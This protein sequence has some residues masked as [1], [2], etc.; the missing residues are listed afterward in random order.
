VKAVL[1]SLLV[2]EEK[3]SVCQLNFGAGL[4][5]GKW[6]RAKVSH[7]LAVEPNEDKLVKGKKQYSVKKDEAEKKKQ[8]TFYEAEFLQEEL[9]VEDLANK[10]NFFMQYQFV[11]CFEG[12]D[13]VIS[14]E[15][16]LTKLFQ[17]VSDL[18][19]IGGYFFGIIN[20]SRAI[21]TQ[22]QKS[23]IKGSKL[24]EIK[25][26]ILQIKFSSMNFEN[27][28]SEYTWEIEKKTHSY[29]LIHF[30]TFQKIA[31]RY[32]FVTLSM[33]NMKEFYEDQKGNFAELL[34]RALPRESADNDHKQAISFYS[35]FVL[36]KQME[37]KERS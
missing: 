16:E 31:Q 19:H 20:D 18:L 24:P 28:G 11:A 15:H 2:R 9:T 1:V 6:Y 7:L 27:L 22:A 33:Q 14:N 12:L 4:D 30:P 21:W 32:G 35:T 29:F 17:N 3:Q 13:E 25:S 36:Q 26:K 5:A 23:L 34:N 37:Y 10:L 8:G